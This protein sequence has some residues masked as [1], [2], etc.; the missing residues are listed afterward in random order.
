M[1]RTLPIM[2]TSQHF[3]SL[4]SSLELNYEAICLFVATGFFFETDTFLK[5]EICLEPAHKYTFNGK[6]QIEKADAYFKWHYS[7]REVSFE[8]VLEEYTTLLKTIIKEQVGDQDVILPLSGGLDSRSQ[9]LI[10]EGLDNPVHSYS[11]AFQGGFPE[12]K[13]SKKIADLCGF[14]FN[15]YFIKPGYLWNCIDE[16]A[17][18][19]KCYS[20]F[21]H[22]RQMAILSELR[23][24]NGVF[25][26]G[27]WGDVLFDRGA[28]EGIEE[29]DLIPLIVKKMV[30]PDGFRLAQKLWEHWH[31]D[32][33]FK[34]YMLSRIEVA[35]SK[36]RIENVSA[37]MRA[38]K[39]SHWAYRWTTTNLS[40][41]ENAH[42]IT[43]PYYD[44]RMCEFVCT[45]PEDY[46][47]DRRL[48]LA[49]LRQDKR[50][51][52]ITWHAHKPFNLNTYKRNKPPYNL[53]YRMRSK[54]KR[55]L[56]GVIGR[57]YVQRNFEL[58]FLGEE[59]NEKLK[60]RIFDPHF[61]QII[62]KDI[63]NDCYS[64]F[65]N[66]DYINNAH[67]VSML[68][69]ISCWYKDIYGTTI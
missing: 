9:A 69:T 23:Q 59:N 41:F 18:I 8:T 4:G 2:P 24:M 13:I 6:G 20:E 51:S 16:L 12:H 56:L 15:S 36:I 5:D 38:F 44:N 53:P 65:R 25:S 61:N 27:H 37:K 34:S 60:S 7:P 48:Q 31:L 52:K 19:N 14:N 45:V 1:I 29:S 17:Q 30:R 39:T 10:L 35:L 64:S 54:V 21:T 55:S 62:S 67:A 40:I 42:P 28:P 32:G 50:L 11:Y 43:L 49:H 22:P 47:K 57:P 58:Q 26:L 68:L 33:D 46:L 3:L 63:V 66:V